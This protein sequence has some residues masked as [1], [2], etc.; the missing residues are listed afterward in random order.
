MRVAVMGAGAVGSY[1]GAKLAAAGFDV[2]FI[3]RGKHLDAMRR[4]GL[5]IK[6]ITGDLHIRSCFAAEAME[7]GAVDV[8][9]FAV[10]TYDTE[11]A[12]TQLQP[13]IG[14]STVIL[15]LQ[16]GVDS[17]AK[18]ARLW[19]RERVRAGV[20]YIAAQL[21]APGIT[22]HSS[23]GRIVLGELAG[24][25]DAVTRRLR[26]SFTRAQVPCE[27]STEIGKAMWEKLVWN[28]PFCALACLLQAPVNTILESESLT[29]LA[30]NCMEEVKEAAHCHGIDLDPSIVERT[31]S[32]SRG[33]GDFKPSMLQ[34]LENGKPLEHEA[35]NGIVLKT[36]RRHGRPA[37]VNETFYATLKFLDQRNRQRATNFAAPM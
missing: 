17:P 32:F 1:F 15:T 21:A 11:L 37:P 10:K 22:E 4:D 18:L 9:L 13:L 33:L 34:D 28:A 26:E 8:I 30:I 5:K 12:A 36:L 31:L 6:S 16:N 35:F 27:I 19:G 29:Q 23:A 7:V 3:A 20:I 2:A 24:T 25:V 14:T